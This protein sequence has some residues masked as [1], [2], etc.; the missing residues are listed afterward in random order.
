M[1]R[2]APPPARTGRRALR[3]R[4]RWRARENTGRG[5]RA[6]W[7]ARVPRWLSPG[8]FL[9]GIRH[10]RWAAREL[11]AVTADGPGGVGGY[12]DADAVDGGA[13][14]LA[15]RLPLGLGQ[16]GRAQ[17]VGQDAGD[18]LQQQ[19]PP[20]LQQ[21]V[22]LAGV[23]GRGQRRRELLDNLPGEVV[24]ERA[25]PVGETG[26]HVEHRG[27]RQAGVY[28]VRDER[29]QCG[30]A[31]QE[32][33]LLQRDQKPGG[34]RL[35]RSGGG[36]CGYSLAQLGPG[37]PQRRLVQC[38]GTGID[39]EQRGQV[40]ARVPGGEQV[41]DPGQRVSAP[42]KPA[43]ERKPLNVLRAVDA[44]A[45]AP[46]RRRQQAHAVILAQGPDRQLGPARELVDRQ[47]HRL[48]N[49]TVNRYGEYRD[50]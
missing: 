33:V 46:L 13:Q 31:N 40:R 6:A 26:D 44:D 20:P 27:R 48:D 28:A 15:G 22:Q 39:A 3:R 17:P 10:F 25:D 37:D 43:D 16:Q 36:Q 30:A 23:P 35:P 18:A 12:A 9:T 7:R 8:D 2:P 19:H 32:V 5:P 38:G 34:D 21:A 1:G 47:F 49:N 11:G 24:R 45:P 41:L 50:G 4:P 14:L 42:L 29:E